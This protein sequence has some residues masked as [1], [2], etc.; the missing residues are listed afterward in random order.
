MDK[1]EHIYVVVAV[2]GKR[3]IYLLPLHYVSMLFFV[4]LRR[5]NTRRV[6]VHMQSTCA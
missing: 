5:F 4:I 6:D 1:T 2:V 3:E